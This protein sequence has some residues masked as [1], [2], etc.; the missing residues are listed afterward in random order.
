MKKCLS[1]YSQ[2]CTIH[3]HLSL[4]Y[5]YSNVIWHRYLAHFNKFNCSQLRLKAG[6]AKKPKY[7]PIQNIREKLGFSGQVCE[8]PLAFHA[9][10]GCDTVSYF[11]GH[12]NKS[13][14]AV[15][16]EYHDLLKDLGKSATLSKEVI[17]DAEKFI[18]HICKSSTE[19]CND[20]QLKMF[21]KCHAP[22]LMPPTSDA[23]KF[24]IEHANYQSLMWKQACHPK[25]DIPLPTDSGWKLDDGLLAPILTTLPPI[26]E[27][28]K[29]IVS[30]SCTKGCVSNKCTCRKWNLQ[31]TEA[32]KCIQSNTVDCKNKTN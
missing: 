9:I 15:F 26:P 14:W 3:S 16:V 25:P 2:L 30:C 5:R 1:L 8:T 31:C 27:A 10:T 6:T 23:A 12:S 18:C 24:H 32:C 17:Q 28:C 19:N 13:A 20:A 4:W 11:S 22:E 29:D 7:V 21:T